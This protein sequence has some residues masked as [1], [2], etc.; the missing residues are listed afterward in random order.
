NYGVILAFRH[1]KASVVSPFR[2]SALLWAMAAGLIIWK[3]IP[4]AVALT[5]SIMIMGSGLY[6]LQAERIGRRRKA[7][8]LAKAARLGIPDVM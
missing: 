8:T 3:E 7:S 5:G 2:Y 6:L 4:N 1:S